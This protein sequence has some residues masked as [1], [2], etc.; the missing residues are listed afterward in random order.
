MRSDRI[1]EEEK[2]VNYTFNWM[3]IW[4]MHF[5]VSSDR[6]KWSLDWNWNCACIFFLV[7]CL[8]TQS[9]SKI[10]PNL[11]IAR[12]RSL[13][14]LFFLSAHINYKIANFQTT[15]ANALHDIRHLLSVFSKNNETIKSNYRFFFFCSLFV[16]EPRKSQQ[17]K[18]TKHMEVEGFLCRF[19][20]AKQKRHT[21]THRDT[22]KRQLNLY[23]IRNRI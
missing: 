3:F 14:F 23:S 18:T 21:H 5:I 4:F 12:K 13:T 6:P 22:L 7:F 10:N 8:A 19:S 15:T 1:V 9:T 16:N 2:I 11:Q 17:N 20:E